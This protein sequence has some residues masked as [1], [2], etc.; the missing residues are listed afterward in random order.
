MALPNNFKDKVLGCWI[1]KSI[2]GTIGGPLEG[3]TNFLDLPYE[4]PQINIDNDDLDLQLVWLHQL[5][6]LGLNI[7]ADDLGDAWLT[8]VKFPFDEYGVAMAN[9]RMGIKPPACGYF[10]NWFTNGM[11]SPIRSEIWACLFP[12][13]PE[14]AGYYAYLDAQVD[15]WDESVWGEILFAC[16]ESIA[17]V[18]SDLHKIIDQG[19]EFIPDH[20]L[21]KQAILLTVKLH[22]EGKS[23]RE[24][25]EKILAD[26]NHHNFTDS[27]QNVAFTIAGLL[28][29]G[30]DFL[31]CILDAS[32]CGY[33][34]DCT[35]ATAG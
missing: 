17:F 7:T 18:E 11:G 19:L 8:H 24:T 9:L 25:R 5:E 6:K 12:G 31:K 16:M 33:D 21:M 20:S 4:Y 34:V 13:R 27:V 10:N 29:G 28:Y 14:I 30:G 3:N 32:A 23:L 22:A 15:H 35:A 1:G 2:G 26:Y